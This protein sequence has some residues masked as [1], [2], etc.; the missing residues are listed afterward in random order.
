M[1]MIVMNWFHSVQHETDPYKSNV[2]LKL[3]LFSMFGF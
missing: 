1:V 2:E 3:M